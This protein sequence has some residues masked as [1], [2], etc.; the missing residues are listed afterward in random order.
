MRLRLALAAGCLACAPLT[1]H[2]QA[3]SPR[4]PDADT[5]RAPVFAWARPETACAVAGLGAAPGAAVRRGMPVLMPDTAEFRTP[6]LRP[7]L[8]AYA[9]PRLGAGPGQPAPSG[10]PDSVVWHRQGAGDT[11]IACPRPR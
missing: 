9:M 11:V 5:T 8:R 3:V 10:L 7:D 4:R 1:A 2:G 6:V